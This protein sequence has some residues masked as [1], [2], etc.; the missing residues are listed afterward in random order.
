MAVNR[1]ELIS[2][3]NELIETLSDSEKGFR[4]A[5]D[6]V[7]DNDLKSLFTRASEQR[8]QFSE[9]LKAQVKHFGGDPAQRGSV[10]GAFHRGWINLKSAIRGG[11]DSAIQAECE[12]GEQAALHNYERILKQN[13]PPNVM[14]MVKHQYTEIKDTLRRLSEMDLAA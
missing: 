12:R 7:K 11:G 6:N 2:C 14:P 10:S 3:L 5:A 9:E 4:T 1:E 8:A 13:L